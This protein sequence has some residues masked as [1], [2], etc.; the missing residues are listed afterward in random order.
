MSAPAP[1][2]LRRSGAPDVLVDY[3]QF[4]AGLKRS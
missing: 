4:V 2:A 1:T 3:A